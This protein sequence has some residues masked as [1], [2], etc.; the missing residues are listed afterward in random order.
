MST[1]PGSKIFAGEF[2]RVLDLAHL[3]TIV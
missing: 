2:T 1:W 3:T